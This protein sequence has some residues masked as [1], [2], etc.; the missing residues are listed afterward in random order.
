MD[1]VS[2]SVDDLIYLPYS[3]IIC[4]PSPDESIV[5]ARVEYL[6]MLG[7]ERIIFEGKTQIGRLNVLGKGCVGIVVKGIWYG[8]DCALKIRRVDANRESL[9]NEGK[10][11][12]MVNCAKIGPKL[13]ESSQDFLVMEFI[14]GVRIIEWIKS[15]KGKGSVAKLK[16]VL[17]D[18]V[19]QCYT[20]DRLNID[21]GELSNLEKHILID[22]DRRAVIIDFETA[23]LMRKTSNLTSSVQYLYIGGPVAKR[24]RRYIGVKD[25]SEIID[26]LREYK[27]LKDERSYKNLLR[28]LKLE[29]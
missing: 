24:I 11:L 26:A 5:K 14:D 10:I 1:S 3:H 20:L 29:V 21:H 9:E 6:K 7:V 4:Y 16:G 25:V 15:L 22:K 2:V 17:K 27:R 13:Y 8:K 19:E 18:I 28:C 23:S 12:K